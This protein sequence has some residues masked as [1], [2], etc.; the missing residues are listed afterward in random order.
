[1]SYEPQCVGEVACVRC[2]ETKPAMA[3][4]ANRNKANGLSSWCRDCH[5][6]DS[7]S[8]TRRAASFGERR[9]ERAVLGLPAGHSRSSLYGE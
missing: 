9:T 7:R 3:F 8:R 4:A 6:S 1:M 5:D 2:G